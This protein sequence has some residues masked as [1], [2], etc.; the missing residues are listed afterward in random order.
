MRRLA[1]P[2]GHIFEVQA[3]EDFVERLAAARPVQAIAELV[4]NSLDAEAS[5]VSIEVD[6]GT[7]GPSAVRIR[8]NGHG[9]PLE[10]APELFAH[11]GG[12]WKR[13]ARV[14]KN[15]KRT[16]HGEE[17]KGRFRALAL[18]RVAEWSVTSKSAS[19][20]LVRYSITLIKDS[21][22][23]FRVS[24]PVIVD[25]DE[26][27][28][29]EVTITELYKAWDF[30]AAG[31]LQELNELYAPYL[32]QYPKVVITVLG[33]KLNPAT[34]IELRKVFELPHIPNGDK[35]S[36]PAELEVIEW[37]SKTERMLYLCNAEGFPLHRVAPGIQA[38]DFDFS[39]YLRSTYVSELHD[40]GTLDLGDLDS[41]LNTAV[42]NAKGLLRDHFKAR[43]AEK[44]K[45]LVDEWKAEE[46]YPYSQEPAT[47]V[48]VAERQVFEIVA[49]DVASSLREFQTQDKR[50][51][52]FQLRMLRAAVER[53]PEELQLILGEVL[54]LSQRKQ[55]ELAKLL[56]RTT[57]SA[58]I[59]ASKLVADRL[60]F[61]NGLESMLFDTEF[62]K[63][64]K[65]RSQ[66]HRLIAANTW[67]FGEEFA[68]TVDDQ[69]LTEVLRKHLQLMKRDVVVNEPVKRLDGSTGIVDLMLSR[70]VPSNREEEH[71]HLVVELKAPTVK[72]GMD[73][74]AQIKSYAFAVQAD[75]RFRGVPTRWTFWVVSND[76]DGFATKDVNQSE[77]PEGLLWEADEPNFSSRIWVKTW[78]QILNDCRTRLR[79]FQQALNYSADKDASLE[80]LKK[81]YARILSGTDT[82]AI[83]TPD[84]TVETG[85]RSA[86]STPAK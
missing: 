44:S 63:H 6:Q 59:S 11:L 37:K 18:G 45:G 40:R 10:E 46:S 23:T 25:G 52:K 81:T 19:G 35:P 3:Q 84:S 49:L 82:G 58:I 1:M 65:E 16:L 74:T 54:G 73:E 33:E 21:A 42:E 76:M 79:I 36:C 66:L 51:R 4:W 5:E 62:K 22:R 9:M 13:T 41:G 80:F 85:T 15:G 53:S 70:R 64:L 47:P 20:Q 17:G 77:R 32:T 50:N 48:Q 56:K 38:P 12:S 71:E 83:D 57:L 28:G 26:K 31:L 8:D 27:S 86:E 67:V 61:V 60:D 68:L 30:A 72:V 14:S 43:T 34:L 39:S 29:V 75:E 55:E 7:L 2:D 78:S 69:S 24:E